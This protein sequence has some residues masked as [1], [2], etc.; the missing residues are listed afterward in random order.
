M[1]P[2]DRE[3]LAKSRFQTIQLCRF[4]G[5]VVM[6]LGMW[7]G[8]GDILREGG[9]RALGVPLLL[10]GAFEALWLPIILARRWKTPPPE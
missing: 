8:F 6:I 1:T 2:E 4:T 3:R 7:I 10:L 5:V 9:W